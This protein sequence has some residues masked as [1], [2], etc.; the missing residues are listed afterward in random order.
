[1]RRTIRRSQFRL[2]RSRHGQPSRRGDARKPGRDQGRD[3]V[4]QRLAG[5]GRRRACRP[6]PCD[7]RAGLDLAAARSSRQAQGNRGDEQSAHLARSQPSDDERSGFA[8]VPGRHV[9]WT[10]RAGGHTARCRQPARGGGD[11]SGGIGRASVEDQI[12]RRRPVVMGPKDLRTI[13]NRTFGAG[14]MPSRRP[15]SN[16]NSTGIGTSAHVRRRRSGRRASN[17]A[18]GEE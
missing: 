4:L 8:R 14:P 2:D 3:G 15:G 7:V 5:R 9:E 6:R 1:M 13:S 16:R 12:E 11:Q 18:R 17:R 10:V